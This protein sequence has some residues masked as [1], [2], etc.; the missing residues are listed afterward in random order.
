MKTK[1]VLEILRMTNHNGPG[2]RTLVLFKGCPLRCAWCSTPESQSSGPEIG[3]HHG[4]CQACGMCVRACPRGALSI[5]DG[6]T[7]I[8]RALCDYCGECERNCFREGLKWYGHVMTVEDILDT[9]RR[10]KILFD[11]SGGG[12]TFSGGEPLMLETDFNVQMFKACQDEGI[13]VGV[14][15][16]GFVPWG[17]IEPCLPY[18]DFFLWDVKLIDE[19]RHMR[20]TGGSNKLILENLI[21]VSELGKPVHVRTPVISTYNDTPEDI[22]AIARFVKE[23][24][25]LQEYAILPMHHLGK[26]RYQCL[27]RPYPL[28]GLPLIPDSRMEE[29][30][31]A[32]EECGIACKIRG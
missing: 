16:C 29:L 10:D 12:V 27:D 15:T 30:R 5:V 8:D 25:T 9:V 6:K 22:Q 32:A 3:I 11:H 31:Q 1:R 24:P 18:V 17:H 23:L 2:F 20:Y 13:S 21:R 14:S 19:E 4:R 28:E 7:I 26:Q